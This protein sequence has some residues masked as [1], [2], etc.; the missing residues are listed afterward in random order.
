MQLTRLYL[1]LI[2]DYKVLMSQIEALL[3]AAL[4]TEGLSPSGSTSLKP[5]AR[6][7]DVQK[8]SVAH[9]NGI[10]VG[11][12][13]LKVN[14]ISGLGSVTEVAKVID[15]CKEQEK[16]LRLALLRGSETSVVEITIS[17]FCEPLGCRIVPLSR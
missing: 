13:I 2:N 16:P 14:N 6:V 5:F 10:L 12:Q 7:D 3:P 8:E 15:E 9:R 17:P 4:P 1:E 11:D